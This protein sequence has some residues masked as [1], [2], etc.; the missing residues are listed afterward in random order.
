MLSSM[1]VVFSVAAGHHIL[2]WVLGTIHLSLVLALIRVVVKFDRDRVV[3]C[4]Q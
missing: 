1:V 4:T 3:K 2:L